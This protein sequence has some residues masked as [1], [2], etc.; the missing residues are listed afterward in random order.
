[1]MKYNI[2]Q[3]DENNIETTKQYAK[4]TI[5]AK[6]IDIPIH[7][8]RKQNKYCDGVIKHD[9]KPHLIYK[10]FYDKIKIYTIKKSIK[11]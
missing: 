6:D 4:L 11:L 3:T 5:L 1:M 7:I 10:E 8:I 9:A 2:I